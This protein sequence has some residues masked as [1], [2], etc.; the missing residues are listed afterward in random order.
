MHCIEY[1]NRPFVPQE[2]IESSAL[3]VVTYM[4]NGA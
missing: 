3:P 1:V 4:L 2:Q